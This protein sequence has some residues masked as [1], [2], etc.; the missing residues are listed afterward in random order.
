MA[1]L[2]FIVNT[3]SG[4]GQGAA[5]GAALAP[6]G[7][8]APIQEL[9]RVLA[10]A[11]PGDRLIAIGGDGTA[12]A[13]IE[14]AA[15]RWA[16]GVVPVGTGND[17][18]RALGWPLRLGDPARRA[19][20]LA[21]APVAPMRRCRIAGGGLSRSFCLY[22]SLG[23]DAAVAGRFHA[24]REA[25]PGWFRSAAGNKAIYA[26]AGLATRAPVLAA[27]VDGESAAAAGS[28]LF[29]AVPSYAGGALPPEPQI[30]AQHRLPAGIGFA[31]ARLRAA[32]WRAWGDRD[33][34]D[35]ELA[36]ALP[37]QVDGEPFVLPAGRY[38]VS[39]SG[40]AWGLAGPAG[41]MEAIPAP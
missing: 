33:G 34:Y 36:A 12:A 1:G 38:R 9:D 8:V 13:V 2:R 21:A 15:G 4:G 35:L 5:L 26:A 19:A 40:Q 11:E 27:T 24:W 31:W 22:L 30:L 7:P 32:A 25:H 16:V 28:L 17:L 18:A 37:A 41:R 14:A 39:V 20:A 6:F 10:A 29:L 23:W 3:R